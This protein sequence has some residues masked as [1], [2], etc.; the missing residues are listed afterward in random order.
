MSNNKSGNSRYSKA[1]S[2]TWRCT[3][4][5]G[6]G[7]EDPQEEIRGDEKKLIRDWKIWKTKD[8]TKDKNCSNNV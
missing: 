7:E 1:I 8:Q 6:Q 5:T 3:E 2:K 4:V